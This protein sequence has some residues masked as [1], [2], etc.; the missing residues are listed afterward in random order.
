[1]WPLWKGSFDTPSQGVKT[2]R[3]RNTALTRAGTNCVFLLLCCA[4]STVETTRQGQGF[5]TPVSPLHFLHT[6]MFAELEFYTWMLASFVHKEHGPAISLKWKH[7]PGDCSQGLCFWWHSTHLR[8]LF[9]FICNFVLVFLVFLDFV[10]S[11][12]GFSV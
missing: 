5:F 10:F 3:L 11:R 7:C 4:H 8:L 1:M 12:Q 6:G 9:G 2:H